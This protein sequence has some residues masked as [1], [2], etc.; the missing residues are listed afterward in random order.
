MSSRPPSRPASPVPQSERLDDAE[1]WE[2]EKMTPETRITRLL[3]E[4]LM[5]KGQTE[6]NLDLQKAENM[7][8]KE[9]IDRLRF[10]LDDV[11]NSSVIG[12]F[13]VGEPLGAA[14]SRT[15]M[16][17]TGDEIHLKSQSTDEDEDEEVVQTTLT[18]RRASLLHCY[19]LAY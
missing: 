3:E 6:A 11:R 16:Q 9:T 5:A 19:L 18:R 8:L 17:E 10:E 13:G 15:M 7:L 14:L 1:R 4:E 2:Q 12:R